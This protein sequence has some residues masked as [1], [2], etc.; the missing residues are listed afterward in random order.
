[1]TSRPLTAEEEA[2]KC[3]AESFRSSLLRDVQAQQKNAQVRLQSTTSP[4]ELL[5]ESSSGAAPSDHDG[6]LTPEHDQSRPSMVQVLSMG[7]KPSMHRMG[8]RALRNC[9]HLLRESVQCKQLVEATELTVRVPGNV[10][11]DD[12]KFVFGAGRSHNILRT[13]KVHKHKRRAKKVFAQRRLGNLE[14]EGDDEADA[15]HQFS[16]QQ[17]EGCPSVSLPEEEK[18][19]VIKVLQ[20]HFLFAALRKEEHSMLVEQMIYVEKRKGDIIC[21]K[22]EKGDACYIILSGIC[23]VKKDEAQVAQLSAGHTF[24]ELAMLYDVPRTATIVCASPRVV[25]SLIRGPIFRRSLARAKERMLNDTLGFLNSHDTF[26]KLSIEEKMMLANALTSQ[27]FEPGTELINENVSITA[28]WMFLVQSGTVEVTDH[29]RNRKALGEGATISGQKMP[30]GQKAVVA[31]ALT[32]VKVFAIGYQVINRLFGN[33]G[34][35]LRRSTIRSFLE[36]VA[37]FRELTDREQMTVAA[38]FQDQHFKTGDIIVSALADPQLVLIME[39]EVVQVKQQ[40]ASSELPPGDEAGSSGGNAEFHCIHPIPKRGSQQLHCNHSEPELMLPHNESFSMPRGGPLDKADVRILQR[41]DVFGEASFQEGGRMEHTLVVRSADAVVCRAGHD[42]VC[43]ALRGYAEKTPPL[44]WI[45]K[46]NRIKR[47]LQTVFPFS[48]LQEEKLDIIVEKFEKVDYR[49][50]DL[51]AKSNHNWRCFCL[52]ADGEVVRQGEDIKDSPQ[53]LGRWEA[54]GTRQLLLGKPWDANFSA[55]AS[56]CCLLTISWQTFSEAAGSLCDELQMKMWYQG[57]EISM[58]FLIDAGF[59]GQGQWGMVRR[60]Q[61]RGLLGEA[62]ALKRLTKRRVIEFQQEAA[63]KLEREILSECCHPLIVRLIATFQDDHSAYFLMEGLFGGDLFT[64]IRDIGDLSEEHILF[65][66]GSLV[67]AIEYTHSRGIIYRDLKPENVMLSAEGFVKLV[68]FGCCTRKT[69]SYTFVGTPEYIAPEVIRGQ[70]YG[71]GV[72]WW[73][74]GVIMYEMICG[75]LPFGEGCTDPMETFRE[76]LE[77][78]LSIPIKAKPEAADLLTSLLERSCEQRLGSCTKNWKHEVREHPY[79]EGLQWDAILE[80]S[81]FP[82]YTTPFQSLHPNIGDLPVFRTGS[83]PAFKLDDPDALDI[84]QRVN[85]A[86]MTDP[87]LDGDSALK[88][89][90]SFPQQEDSAEGDLDNGFLNEEEIPRPPSPGADL[91]CFE[92]F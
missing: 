66:G 36:S 53:S 15:S 46:R 21:N 61:I 69:R 16:S 85:S 18:R 3:R 52:L 71:K 34:E 87:T 20:K 42:E 30:Y 31:K 17:A 78:P 44:T 73:S 14:T 13:K 11:C 81:I 2:I 80:H 60:V 8:T 6:R 39:G 25:L 12:D 77:K 91:S 41:G 65:F 40:Q 74:L 23:S 47:K 63:T 4:L 79:F 67:L 1:V 58:D 38:L 72:D 54:F 56:G 76:I 5:P 90:T 88:A 10:G 55:A 92:G 50:N 82:P 28:E 75:P 19:E 70:G 35:V 68:D 37:F 7:S 27:T 89:I 33:I 62:F 43:R 86:P 51:I 24:G 32:S 64:A 45:I 29:Y 57:L 22:D 9:D 59:L 26:S 84:I 48:A 83:M 49:P